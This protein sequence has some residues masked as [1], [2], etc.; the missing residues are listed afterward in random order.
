[1]RIGVFDSGIGGKVVAMSLQQSL[2]DVEI[3]L[4]NDQENMPYG[5]KTRNRVIELTIDAVKPLIDVKCDV[6]IIACNTASTTALLPLRTKYPN[7]KFI[8]L[9]PMIKPAAKI[10]KT[11]RIAVCATPR[12]LKSKRY[13]ELKNTWANDIKVIEPDCSSW[14]NLIEHNEIDEIDLAA[15]INS[16]IEQKVDVIVLGCTHY[17]LIKQQIIDIVGSKITVLEP[18]NTIA[19]RIKNII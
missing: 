5:D 6:I 4:I 15:T 8:G 9:D 12:T 10:T 1:M 7:Q 11:N 14:A 17:H 19:E 13:N 18:T 2:V 16:L 3:V